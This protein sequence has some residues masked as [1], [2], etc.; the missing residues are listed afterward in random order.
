MLTGEEKREEKRILL[1]RILRSSV[2]LPGGF[3]FIGTKFF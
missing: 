2:L 3:W 1:C